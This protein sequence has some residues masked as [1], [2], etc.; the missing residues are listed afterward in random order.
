MA[1]FT[2]RATLSYNNVS[3]DSNI[4]TGE[5]T[6]V[7]SASKTALEDD[8]SANC[9]NTYL[10]NI[11]NS[12][13]TAFTGLTVTDNLGEY[14][15]NSSTRTPLSYIDGSLKYFS[16][17]TLQPALTPTSTAPLTVSG[18]TVPANGNAMIIYKAY[19]N[20]YA[21]LG[22]GASITNTATIS[23]AG[24]T[25]DIEVS[26]T[27]NHANE[28]DLSITKTLSPE[29]VTENS[30]ITYTFVIQN[31]GAAPVTAAAN[32]A[33]TDTFNPQLKN[34]T[35]TLSSASLSAAG[36]PSVPKILSESTDY[37]YGAD[38]GLFQTMAGKITVPAATYTVNSDGAWTITP[39]VTVLKVTGTI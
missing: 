12:G 10:I 38:T 30:E 37:T 14:A 13:A 34:I 7:L 1:T 32:A 19:A 29:T 24:L 5:L 25:N 33:V 23:G 6:E 11:T 28:S 27:V 31:K 21:P 20:E 4:V 36:T 2:N 18:I 26:E 22:A 8:Y 17:G 3:T 15:F 9:P 35:A 39:G 16:N